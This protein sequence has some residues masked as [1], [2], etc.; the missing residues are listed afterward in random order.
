MERWLC[1][2]ERLARIER[3]CAVERLA[4]MERWCAVEQPARLEHWHEPSHPGRMGFVLKQLD[5]GIQEWIHNKMQLVLLTAIGRTLI[6]I[7]W[8]SKD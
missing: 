3:W 7:L 2:V 8:L 6:Y 4:R 1:A 5:P